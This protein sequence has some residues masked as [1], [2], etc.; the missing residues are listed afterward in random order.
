VYLRFLEL[1]RRIRASYWFIPSLMALAAFV[2]SIILVS[3]DIRL[4]RDWIDDIPWLY[5][6]EPEG[7][8]A[9]LS[10][11]AGSVISVA[12]V[13]FSITIAAL[14]LASSQYG[15]RLIAG[16]MRDRGNQ[17]VLG[18]YTSTFL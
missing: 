17:F 4:G 6:N 15:P 2:L 10:T 13:T 3:I 7:A 11:I 9:M 16:F 14:S 12:G 5:A 1:I 18:T 8:R